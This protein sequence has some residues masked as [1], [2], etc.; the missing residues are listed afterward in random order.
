MVL[1]ITIDAN[2][3]AHD[4]YDGYDTY[5]VHVGDHRILTVVTNCRGT[6]AKWLNDVAK[7]IK[8]RSPTTLLVGVSAEHESLVYDKSGLR[9]QPYDLLNLCIGSH[10]L[11]YQIE[12][13]DYDRGSKAYQ[14]H[15][16]DFFDNPRVVAVGMNMNSVAQKLD[17]DHGIKMRNQLDL[18][19]MAMKRFNKE[20]C[21][22]LDNIAKNLVGRHIEVVR[23]V[24]IHWNRWRI[25][26]Q[27][28]K[29]TT[30]DAYLCYLGRVDYPEHEGL[31]LI[32]SSHPEQKLLLAFLLAV[33][34]LNL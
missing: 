32:Y 4:R 20:D 31:R 8:N 30:L 13:S 21:C 6:L 24:R 11:V 14:K 12:E 23:P 19:E 3:E 15:L 2:E 7:S 33:S 29:Y 5:T 28:V 17:R 34:T 22:D 16:R 10:C 1:P 27:K 25:N 9:D 26:R 18:K